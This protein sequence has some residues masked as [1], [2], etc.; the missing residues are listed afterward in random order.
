MLLTQYR[1]HIEFYP[2]Q[3]LAPMLLYPMVYLIYVVNAEI[4][5]DL[6]PNSENEGVENRNPGVYH[7]FTTRLLS[8]LMCC[9]S[10][11][12]ICLLTGMS[13]VLT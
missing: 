9:L 13:W 1:T 10:I 8:F 6:L 3:I 4:N 2:S 12:N 11:H 7:Y 5:Y